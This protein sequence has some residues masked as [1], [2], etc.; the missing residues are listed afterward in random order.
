ARQEKFGLFLRKRTTLAM[1]AFLCTVAACILVTL[2]QVLA[3]YSRGAAVTD[4]G[5]GGGGACYM[6][7]EWKF[8]LPF[9][10]L[11]AVIF[12]VLGCKLRDVDD[13]L[14]I[15]SELRVNFMLYLLFGF[16]YFVL[17]LHYRYRT[18]EEVPTS[19]QLLI[20]AMVVL[21]MV[22]TMWASVGGLEDAFDMMGWDYRS[23]FFYGGGGDEDGEASTWGPSSHGTGSAA[24]VA[25]EPRRATTT[26]SDVKRWRQHYSDVP[27]I[28]RN[29]NMSAAFGALAN[30]FLC[31]ESYNFLVSISEYR[32]FTGMGAGPGLQHLLFMD[33]CKAFVMVNAEQEINI[34]HD[35]RQ[36]ILR[37]MA[38]REFSPLRESERADIFLD[39]EREVCQMLQLNLLSTFHNSAVFTETCAATDVEHVEWDLEEEKGLMGSGDEAS[40]G[41]AV[42][43]ARRG[44]GSGRHGSADDVDASWQGSGSDTASWRGSGSALLSHLSLSSSTVPAPSR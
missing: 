11:Q 37:Y 31:A 26:R 4:A 25:A 28:M 1:E 30:R 6:M 42:E 17:T 12:G 35:Q 23:A 19:L 40:E 34:S 5:A 14:N 43:M 20:S 9:C 13:L 8:L 2:S 27:S 38:Y 44:G 18:D 16:P 21:A 41:G 32:A 15:S 33:L 7:M 10:V 29:A 36:Q 24:S 39:A 22:N 3:P